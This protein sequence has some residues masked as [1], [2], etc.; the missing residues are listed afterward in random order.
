[1]HLF[2]RL[3]TLVFAAGMRQLRRRLPDLEPGEWI[4]VCIALGF[5]V[6]AGVPFYYYWNRRRR[7]EEP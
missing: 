7:L 4:V 2:D 1:M 5:N 6:T 3:G